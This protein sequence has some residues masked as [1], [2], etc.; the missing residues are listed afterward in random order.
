[1]MKITCATGNKQKFGIGKA[2]LA[3]YDIDLIQKHLVID[4]IQGENHELVLKDKA[5]KAYEQLGESVVV[6]DDWWDIPALGGFPGAYMKSINHWFSVEDYIALMRDKTNRQAILHAFLCYFDGSTYTLFSVDLI[7]HIIESPR[8]K[9]GPAAQ[10]VTVM[11]FDNGLTV[12]E[13]YDQGVEHAPHRLEAFHQLW[14]N[15]GKYIKGAIE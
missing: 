9:S 13:I 1:M 11:D 7:G 3:Q 4:E 15:F 6:T 5:R 2:I 14:S 8:G 12:S 10:Q